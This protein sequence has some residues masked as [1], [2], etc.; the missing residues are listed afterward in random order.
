MPVNRYV[1]P[2]RNADASIP[3]DVSAMTRSSVPSVARTVNV[4]SPLEARFG[5]PTA[6]PSRRASDPSVASPIWA[7]RSERGAG[8]AAEPTTVT[9]PLVGRSSSWPYGRRQRPTGLEE[10]A[11]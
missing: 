9:P 11:A 7:P 4:R 2:S 8:K 1:D 5:L 10:R 6:T 3:A